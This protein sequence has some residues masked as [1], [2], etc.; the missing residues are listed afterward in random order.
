[1]SE[2]VHISKRRVVYTMPAVDTVTVRRDEP[3]HA[4][5]TGPLTMDLYYAPDSKQG[6]PSPAVIFVTGFSDL[7]AQKILGCTLK[8]MASFVSWAELVAASGLVA[9]TYT[10]REPAGD[11]HLVVQHLRQNAARLNIDEKRIGI[12]ACSGHAPTALSV[13]MQHRQ[14]YLRCAVLC[15]PYMLDLDGS[16]SVA[17][18]AKQFRFVNP[19]SEKSVEDLS[20]HIPLFLARAGQDQMPGLNDALDR[21]VAKALMANLPVTF[22]NHALAPHA[23]D[24]FEDSAV[25]R[26]VIRQVLA[27]LRFHLLT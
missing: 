4:T 13:L 12:W 22:V 16:S 15:Y 5:D 17:D 21:F 14:D 1:M 20:R 26:E 7:G 6:G 23:F 9:V 8:E 2:D 27:F 24:L 10:N 11:V 25:S 3:Y 18:A 19:C